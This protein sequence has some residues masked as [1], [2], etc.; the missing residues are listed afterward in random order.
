MF[1]FSLIFDVN[2]FIFLKKR[3]CESIKPH[4]SERDGAQ[5]QNPSHGFNCKH[6]TLN[7][8]GTTMSWTVTRWTGS[9]HAPPGF[10]PPG[11]VN[12]GKWDEVKKKVITVGSGLFLNAVG[13][14]EDFWCVRYLLIVY[15]KNGCGG[16]FLTFR[17]R[18]Q[19]LA[20]QLFAS[21]GS[22]GAFLVVHFL[23]ASLCTIRAISYVVGSMV[24]T[25]MQPISKQ[26]PQKNKQSVSGSVLS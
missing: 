21:L 3:L 19:R 16:P 9:A 12:V 23:C 6:A 18:W 17:R 24:D 2:L 20:S 5:L 22:S 10:P 7:P 14:M 26:H 13:C 4:H 11:G 1:A 25:C 15:W 8:P